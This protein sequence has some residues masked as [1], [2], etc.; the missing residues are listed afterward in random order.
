MRK[1]LEG[2]VSET[3]AV[4][5][6]SDF[7]KHQVSSLPSARRTRSPHLTICFV[8]QQYPSIKT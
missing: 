3:P 1:S 2:A 5:N 4:K 6:W 8:S 7:I